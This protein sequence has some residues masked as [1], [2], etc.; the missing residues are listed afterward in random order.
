MTFNSSCFVC[1]FPAFVLVYYLFPARFRN[2]LLLLGSCF[3]YAVYSPILILYLAVIT[4]INYLFGIK[5]SRFEN[6]D[7]RRKGFMTAGICIDLAVLMFYK[8]FNFISLNLH[9]LISGK[10]DAFLLKL[11][12]P[13]GISFITFTLISYLVDVYRGTISAEKD[14]IQ[15]AVYVSFF[16]KVVQGPITRAGDFI[17]QM[18]KEH[19]FDIQ[20][21][22]EGFIMI[23]YG[24]FMKMVVADTLGVAVD[25]IYLDP[26]TRPGAT[27]LFGTFLFAI[28]IYCDFAG[29]SL[30]A[31][32]CAKILGFEL[33]RNFRQPYLSGSVGEFWRRWHMSLNTWLTQYVYIPLGGSRC[34][35]ARTTANTLITFGLSG[36]WHGADWGYVIWGLLNGVYV[37]VERLAGKFLFPGKGRKDKDPSGTEETK[38]MAP[39]R[40]LAC[41][42]KRVVTFILISFSWIF[43]RAQSLEKASLIIYRI[44]HRFLFGGVIRFMAKKLSL[45]A[46]NLLYN[47][48]V[49]YGWRKVFLGLLVVLIIDLVSQKYDLPCILAK[50]GRIIRWTVEIL[51]L[52]VVIVFGVYGF[53]YDASAFIYSAF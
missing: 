13:L 44:T 29:Y 37:S 18:E 7:R 2:V 1:F 10:G 32:G 16:P 42:I 19:R 53:G 8:Y 47:L 15:F 9:S 14:F 50:S 34:S 24:E 27:L 6:G 38:G 28:Q 25:F 49:V 39:G 5:I 51:L 12:V 26:D 48:D 40:I 30:I 33:K 22:R 52:M 17:P 35:E 43:F 31:I 20:L 21:A 11:L 36:L 45:G 41:L 4:V 46:G 3:F 23:L